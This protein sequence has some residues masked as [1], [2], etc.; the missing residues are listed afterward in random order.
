MAR[1]NPFPRAKFVAQQSLGGARAGVQRAS[2]E[3]RSGMSLADSI[4]APPSIANFDQTDPRYAGKSDNVENVY[5]PAPAAPAMPRSG[6][7]Q[8][9]NWLTTGVLR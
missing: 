4:Y 7:A 3:F 8:V 9:W 2:E 1:L 5:L 6:L